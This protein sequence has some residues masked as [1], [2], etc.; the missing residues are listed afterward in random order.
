MSTNKQL[1][2]NTVI[3]SLQK[4]WGSKAVTT[5]SHFHSASRVP[6]G[7]EELDTLLDGGVP[8][9]RFV[10]L[11]GNPTSGMS[12]LALSVLANTQNTQEIGAYIDLGHTFDPDYAVFCGVNLTEMLLLRPKFEA[13][14]S[15]LADLV[16]SRAL[17]CIVFNATFNLNAPQRNQVAQT[18]ESLRSALTQSGCVLLLLTQPI[19]QDSL[20]QYAHAQLFIEFHDWLILDEEISGYLANVT[21]LK[22][23]GT[24]EGK[25]VTISIHAG[26]G[27]R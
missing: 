22:Y 20:R 21:V 7:F 2:L 8:R 25:T 11:M 23:K 4:Q 12:T 19:K 14:L 1:D 13:A 15:F 10:H 3:L 18:I 24:H 27:T 17:G 26:E 5:A 16:F 9:G 6:T